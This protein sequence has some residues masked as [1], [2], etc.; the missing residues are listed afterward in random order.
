MAIMNI[1]FIP[2]SLITVANQIRV[3]DIY[4]DILIL[5]F[6]KNPKKYH[7]LFPFSEKDIRKEDGE[8][9]SKKK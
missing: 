4:D 1:I 5:L 6:N 8:K 7:H 9:V 3:L 2:F